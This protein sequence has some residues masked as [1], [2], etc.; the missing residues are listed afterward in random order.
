MYELFPSPLKPAAPSPLSLWLTFSPPAK[1]LFSTSR[2]VPYVLPPLL[3]PSRIPVTGSP[4]PTSLPECVLLTDRPSYRNGRPMRTTR[5]CA[6][7]FFSIVPPSFLLPHPPFHFFPH[8]SDQTVRRKSLPAVRFV[9]RKISTTHSPM[10][11][12]IQTQSPGIVTRL[13]ADSALA[14]QRRIEVRHLDETVGD[15]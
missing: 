7:L 1:S 9:P 12:I 5:P 14:R 4:R 11:C 8:G 15:S 6:S 2:G 13:T 3:S 10:K